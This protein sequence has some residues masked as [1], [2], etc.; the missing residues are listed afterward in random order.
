MSEYNSI[1]GKS[2]LLLESLIDYYKVNMHIFTCI[3][4][5]KNSISLR[6]LDWLVTNYSKK[7]N[8]IYS[9]NNT[10]F[11]VYLDYKNQLKAY[12]KKLFDP[13]CRRER[14]KLNTTTFEWDITY[15]KIC[16]DKY[17][18]TT[19]GQLNFFKWF[20]ENKI[21]NYAIEN[22]NII[23]KD[24]TETLNTSKKCKK[25]CELSSCASKSLYSYKTTSVINF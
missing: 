18:I 11:N 22:I 12:S 24:M 23:D 15:D 7:H 9:I 5:N 10:H 21:L 8:V 6:I 25:R 20:I 17:I 14:I 19:V 1:N 2:L 4:I 3:L 13:F 16:E